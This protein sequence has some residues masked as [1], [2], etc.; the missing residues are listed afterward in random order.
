[1][2]ERKAMW[3]MGLLLGLVFGMISP[4]FSGEPTEQVKQTTEK[5]LSILTNPALRQPSR[6]EEKKRLISRT[7]DERFDWEE[8]SKRALA[9]HWASRSPE[10]KKE[11][12]RLFRDLLERTYLDKV[13]LYSGETA[14]Y[15]GESIDGNFAV[16]KIK[17][18]TAKGKEIPVEYRMTKKGADWLVY[19]ISVEGV[20]LVNNYRVQFN[21]LLA[22]SSFKELLQKLRDK[23]S[24]PESGKMGEPTRE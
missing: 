11:F 1:M 7:V 5:I 17:V 18:L 13:D 20:S 16:V 9:R 21:S 8:M 22:K 2:R 3:G 23:V 24:L 14:R 15:E 12:V 4:G 10:E 6:N 19:D